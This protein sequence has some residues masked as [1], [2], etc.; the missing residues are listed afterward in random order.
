LAASLDLL[1]YLARRCECL[2]DLLVLSQIS[3]R[4]EIMRQTKTA[5][6]AGAGRL[7]F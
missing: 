1:K 2:I 7:V 6:G 3:N 5:P 4:L